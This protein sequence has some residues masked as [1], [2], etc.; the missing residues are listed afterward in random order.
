MKQYQDKNAK[1]WFFAPTLV[2]AMMLVVCGG[3]CFLPGCGSSDSSE[4]ASTA[5]EDEAERFQEEYLQYAV[6]NLQRIEQFAGG[7]MRQQI[8]DRLNQWMPTQTLPPGWEAE[9]MLETLPS[10]VKV[11][12][13]QLA[14]KRFSVSDGYTLQQAIW[15]RELSKWTCG[16]ANDPVERGAELFDWMVRNIQLQKAAEDGL[17]KIPKLPWET[18]FF[19][20]GAAVDRAWVFMLAARQQS[21]DAVML[22]VPSQ[23]KPEELIPWAIGLLKEKE[24]YLFEPELGLPIPAKDGVSLEGMRLVIKPATLGQV[25]EDP[26]ILNQLDLSEEE[27]YPI[28][29]EQVKNAV[30]MIPASS[31]SLS[32]RFALVESRMV[33]DQR[34]VL[35]VQP[36]ALAKELREVNGLAEDRV[37]LWPRPF[38]VEEI[39]GHLDPELEKTFDNAMLPFLVGQGTPLWKGRAAHIMGKLT[40][41][42]GATYY[43]QKARPSNR[44]LLDYEEVFLEG[45]PTQTPKDAEMIHAFYRAKQ[46]AS[47][48]LGL[49][50]Y[51][52]DDQTAAI[53]YFLNRTLKVAV[54]G[55]WHPGAI[56][57]LGRSLERVGQLEE[58][59]KVLSANPSL[60]SVYG[61]RL[62][63]KWL[64]PQREPAAEVTPP[65]VEEE[66]KPAV[67]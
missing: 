51:S 12:L 6:E 30:A 57:N 24:L 35:T 47:Y 45:D 25:I 33:G 34:A 19:G 38:V 10:T 13:E 9:A 31:A 40:G 60:P 23:D 46:D 29:A 66:A 37:W 54:S 20:R 14:G 27:K 48:W 22:M 67:E 32:A 1:G 44:Q 53:D 50:D 26:T 17:G 55:P 39:R 42:Q 8:V 5:T 61:N 62:R 49:V 3:L 56:Y 59:A 28:T 36:S 18:L 7:E 52:L 15:M 11:D 58:A 16:D 2:V 43:Y 41:E 65:A 21:L 63:A 4:S 64:V